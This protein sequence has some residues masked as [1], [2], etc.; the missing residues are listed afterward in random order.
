M[1]TAPV[2]VGGY[3]HWGVNVSV[4]LATAIVVGLCVLV[5]YEGLSLLTRGLA[6]LRGKARR[7]ILRGIF[8]VLVLHVLEIWIFGLALYVLLLIDPLFGRIHGIEPHSIF[9]YVYF[10]AVTYTTVGF[11]DVIPF[12]PLRFM[13]GTEALAGFVLL[14][15]SASFTFVEMQRYWKRD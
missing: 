7:H 11:G 13:V 6:H 5:H 2:V 14:T 1:A 10:S 8:G 9:D 12:G 3:H 15:W 4:A